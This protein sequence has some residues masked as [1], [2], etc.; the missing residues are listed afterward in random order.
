M[1]RA[2]ERAHEIGA[3]TLQVF[4]DNPTAWKRRSEPPKEAIAFRSRLAD[5]DVG[6]V[7]I[8]AA[9]LVNLAGPDDEL[10]GRSVR[11]LAEELRVAPGFSAAFVNVHVGS[12]RGSG[13]EAGTARVAE[14]IRLALAETDGGPGSAVLVL[15]NSAGGGFGLGAT[16]EELAAIDGAARAA[17]VDPD[18][19]AYC[20]DTAHAW[21]AGYRISEPDEVDALLAALDERIGRGRIRMVHLN[22]SKAACGSHA[23]RHEHLGA[24]SI[25][26]RGLARILTHPGLAGATYYLETPGMDEGYDAVNVARALALAAGEPLPEL[27]P[28]AANV[29]GSRART[30]PRP[31]EGRGARKGVPGGRG[32][33]KGVPGA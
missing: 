31:P 13:T 10:F 12:H 18:R 23:D 5:L 8:H 25:G 32:S 30:G 17:G 6:P 1:V 33:R 3:T 29:A 15:E 16:V 4:A 28:E 22:D 14:G 21:G 19:F 2:V 27:P 24:G 20:L 9:Y 26:P 11:L 7:A